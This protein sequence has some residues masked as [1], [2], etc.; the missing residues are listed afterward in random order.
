M[1]II[2]GYQLRAAVLVCLF[3]SF[4]WLPQAEGGSPLW[5]RAWFAAPS[6]G[7]GAENRFSLRAVRQEG[8]HLT[9]E[10][11]YFQVEN[12]NPPVAVIEG[13]DTGESGFWPDVTSQVKNER[14]G[15]W[16]TIAKPFNH[17][18]RRKIT[19]KPGEFN[20]ELLVALDVFYPFVGKYKLGRLVLKTGEITMFELNK[21]LEEESEAPNKTDK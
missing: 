11:T 4:E 10:C 7:Y 18:H 1:R 17:G 20:Q 8:L 13:T 12:Q 2:L 3:C 15:K 6:G 14:T 16:E 19:I 5:Q 21:L 9:G